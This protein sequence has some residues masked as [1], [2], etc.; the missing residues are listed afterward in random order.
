MIP[1]CLIARYKT[2]VASVR[3]PRRE[4]SWEL[5]YGFGKPPW[6]AD[7]GIRNHHF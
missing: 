2:R 1:N 7:P 6:Q 3:I 4:Q 5:V